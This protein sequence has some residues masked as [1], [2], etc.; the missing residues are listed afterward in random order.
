MSKEQNPQFLP[1][2]A[3]PSNAEIQGEKDPIRRDI[4]AAM[5]R[6]LLGCPRHVPPGSTSVSHL[7]Q[8]AQIGRHHLYQSHP[9]LRD[10]YS[11]LCD[12]ADRPTEKEAAL[13]AA[14]DRTKT[15]LTRMRELQT[16]TRQQ[17]SD[18]RAL[19]EVLARAI[20]VLQEELHQEQIKAERLADRL[21][22]IEKQP[23]P[24]SPVVLLHRRQRRE[25][26]RT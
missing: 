2:M 19:T 9:D 5:Q 26:E 25:P 16:R 3:P 6:I 10:R 13:R 1:T 14:L 7:A 18:W 11:Y 17:A 8:E 21:G 20:N 12:R 22:R 24:S 15:E 23:A 4:L